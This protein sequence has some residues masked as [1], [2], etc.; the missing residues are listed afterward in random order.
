[1]SKYSTQFKLSAIGAFLSGAYGFRRVGADFGVDPT[2]LRRWIAAYRQHGEQGVTPRARQS[3]TTEFKLMVLQTKWRDHLSLRE[4]AALFNL[5]CSSQV[6]R[7]EREYYS[8][9]IEAPRP[10]PQGLPVVMSKPKFPKPQTPLPSESIK[11]EDLTHDQLLARL[12]Q[13]RVENAY[14]KKLKALREEKE[15]QAAAGKKKPG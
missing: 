1:M 2:L 7:W 6:G 4:V 14:L 12:Y 5:G 11:D 3:Y 13:A 15:R 9:A 10:G 8:S